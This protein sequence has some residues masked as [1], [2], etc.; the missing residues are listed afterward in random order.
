MS[1]ILLTAGEARAI[2]NSNYTYKKNLTR[3][4]DNIKITAEK[5]SRSLIAAY[6]KSDTELVDYLIANLKDYGY[7]VEVIRP[8]LSRNVYL[9]ISW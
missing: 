7:K 1:D 2:S 8:V 6:A 4:M 5:S 3:L 9:N